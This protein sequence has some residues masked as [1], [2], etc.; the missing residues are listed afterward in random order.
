[1]RLFRRE[2]P[3][4]PEK[5]NVFVVE[6]SLAA[7]AVFIPFSAIGSNIAFLCFFVAAL[8]YYFRYGKNVARPQLTIVLLPSLILAAYLLSF[9]NSENIKR[10]L[11]T[12]ELG[13]F[14]L[15]IPLSVWLTA[16]V[17][18]NG[19]AERTLKIFFWS[20]LIL[21]CLSYLN[22][23][24]RSGRFFPGDEE[25]PFT[26]FE[27]FS[28]YSF[29]WFI[30]GLHPTY[31]SIYILFA[32]VILAVHMEFSWWAKILIGCLFAFFLLIL[33]AK[34]QLVIFC[35][36]IAVI[37]WHQIKFKPLHKVI[38]AL[39]ILCV[40]LGAAALNRQIVYRFTTEAKTSNGGDRFFLWNIG[41]DI[42]SQNPIIGVGIGDRNDV[43]NARL[44]E[45]GYLNGLNLHNQFLDYMMAMGIPGVAVLLFV[46]GYPYF[47]RVDLTFGL[48]LVIITISLTT[49][50]LLYRQWGAHFFLLFYSLL[51]IISNFSGTKGLHAPQ[52]QIS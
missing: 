18:R 36:L 14:F 4:T 42:I 2:L 45:R 19:I 46:L 29:S 16:S 9:I 31:L 44:G 50:S 52:T 32:V 40:F 13:S 33:S 35:L 1:M 34:N 10:A 23:V 24:I 28:R 51:A 17:I 49:E 47:A 22:I 8:T 6:L 26:Y 41:V 20:I 15:M 11:T 39:A 7:A 21:C 30:N 5:I 25:V 12:L 37:V 43:V 38:L 3:N 27:Y 48:F